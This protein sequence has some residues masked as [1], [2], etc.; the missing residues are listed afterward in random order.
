[1]TQ[2]DVKDD[3]GIAFVEDS[4]FRN[5][6]PAI[7][8]VGVGYQISEK[9][10]TQLSFNTYFDKQADR[11]GLEDS[12]GSNMIEIG[13]GLEYDLSDNISVS[14]GFLRGITGVN[15]GYQ[16]D[17]SYSNSS[18]TIGFGG[19][20]RLN[21]QLSFDLGFLY[22]MYDDYVIDYPAQGPFPAYSE[23]FDKKT[24]DIAIGVNYKF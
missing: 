16:T 2:K 7:L 14:A 15:D 12:I 3:M 9:F 22:T 8:G 4:T 21:E 11:S 13:L 19:Q 18:T 20:Y 24:M 6:V 5:D 1:L 17:I 23:T 10:R